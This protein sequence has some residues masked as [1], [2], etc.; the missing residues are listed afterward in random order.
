MT[1]NG[2]ILE[3]RNHFEK[4]SWSNDIIRST[5]VFKLYDQYNIQ[6]RTIPKIHTEND[7]FLESWFVFRR[8]YCE[9]LIEICLELLL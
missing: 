5:S 2:L 3:I 4:V 8:W 1:F 7:F 6:T 9:M